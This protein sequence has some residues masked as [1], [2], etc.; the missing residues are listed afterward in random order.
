M[1]APAEQTN[2]EESI[3]KRG[4]QNVDLREYIASLDRTN[5]ALQ[6][7]TRTNFRANQPTIA[8]M[9]GLLKYGTKQLEDAFRS[10]VQQSCAQK[11]D[12]L[13][14]VAKSESILPDYCSYTDTM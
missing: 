5:L 14:Y 13:E 9:T 1:R 6:D 10:I 11:V 2:Q 4:L 7:L 3:I 12:P 8:N